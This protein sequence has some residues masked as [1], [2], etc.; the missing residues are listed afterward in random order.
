MSL[1]RNL[2][3]LGFDALQSDTI[4]PNCFCKKLLPLY[5]GHPTDRISNFLRNVGTFY[6]TT[7]RQIAKDIN[8]DAF[9][10]IFKILNKL[11]SLLQKQIFLVLFLGITSTFFLAQGISQVTETNIAELQSGYFNKFNFVKKQVCG[12]VIFLLRHKMR[13]FC[14]A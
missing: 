2:T 1:V 7:R 13:D 12:Y 10:C 14:Y 8:I 3:S 9:C 5:S 11:V 4:L 6:Q